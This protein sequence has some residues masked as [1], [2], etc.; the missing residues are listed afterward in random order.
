M[1]KDRPSILLTAEIFKKSRIVGNT[2]TVLA[3]AF[4]VIFLLEING[5]FIC[6]AINE[7]W[8]DL[9]SGYSNLSLKSQPLDALTTISPHLLELN[10]CNICVK[11]SG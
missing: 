5:T 2:S 4:E 9:C 8:E 3:M 6:S 11:E 1:F 7:P 10:N